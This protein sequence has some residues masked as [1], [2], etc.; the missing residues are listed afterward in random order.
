MYWSLFPIP[1]RNNTSVLL[2]CCTQTLPHRL[3]PVGMKMTVDMLACAV[4]SGRAPL[5]RPHTARPIAQC[6]ALAQAE[7]V[8]GETSENLFSFVV[9]MRLNT[10]LDAWYW[11][12]PVVFLFLRSVRAR[13]PEDTPLP[14]PSYKYNEW[15]NDR[16]HLGS[17][18][19]LSR[20]KGVCSVIQT[21]PTCRG[22]VTLSCAAVGK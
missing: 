11:C 19:R 12:W 20:G 13:Y 7:T 8:R 6:V 2:S 14:T 21:K 17:T 3:P 22:K 4:P 10:D 18:P 16:K 5:R 1:S 15:A 9:T